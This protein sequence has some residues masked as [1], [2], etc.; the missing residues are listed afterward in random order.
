L[1]FVAAGISESTNLGQLYC[2][3]DKPLGIASLTGKDKEGDIIPAEVINRFL[4]DAKEG[5][6][7]GIATKGFSTSPLVDPAMRKFLKIPNDI[8]DGVYVSDVYTIGTGCDILKNGDVLLGIEGKPINPYGRYE[9]KKFGTLLFDY[10]ITSKTAGDDITFEVWRDG[11]RQHLSA[12]AKR[13]EASD[14]L[15]PWYEFDTQPQYAVIGG[16]I[17]QKM[18][19]TYLSDR[20]EDWQGKVEPHLY[21]YLVNSAFKPTSERTDIVVL[22]YCMPAN[23][24]I[25]YHDMSQIIVDKINGMKIR[26]MSDIPKALAVNPD[27]KFIVIEFEMEKPAVVLS[28]IEIDK[29]NESIAQIYGID[30]LMNINQ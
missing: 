13:F 9:D 18:T 7:N 14:M 30:K 22:S 27:S 8:R 11:K 2:L 1:T 21:N 19:Q 6:Y 29:A 3:D 15:V 5:K 24:N 12:K 25:G 26:R 16:C 10:L 20:G 17:L 23:I 28:R 4:K